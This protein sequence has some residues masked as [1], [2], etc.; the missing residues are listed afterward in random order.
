M[1]ILEC[2]NLFFTTTALSVDFL[3]NHCINGVHEIQQMHKR[4]ANR[5]A[6]V[7]HYVVTKTTPKI[8]FMLS[9]RR[10]SD[11]A[12]GGVYWIRCGL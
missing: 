7:Q 3:E 4:E 5:F 9:E 11:E 8:E 1:Q 12:D 6:E 10:Q 2:V